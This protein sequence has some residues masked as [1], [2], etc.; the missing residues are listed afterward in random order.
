MKATSCSVGAGS[1]PD[2]SNRWHLRILAPDKNFTGA[3]GEVASSNRRL[4]DVRLVAH[5]YFGVPH[6]R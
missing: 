5:S 4:A 3:P 6:W 2:H 1:A